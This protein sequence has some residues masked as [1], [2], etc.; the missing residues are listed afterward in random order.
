MINVF[1]PVGGFNDDPK[2]EFCKTVNLRNVYN[3]LM[4][5]HVSSL[6][7]TRAKNSKLLRFRPFMLVPDIVAEKRVEEQDVLQ[8]LSALHAHFEEQSRHGFT[9]FD[10]VKT[11]R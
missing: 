1:K 10:I 8:E 2:H 3:H 7:F 4:K 11:A 5:K 6:K 9:F